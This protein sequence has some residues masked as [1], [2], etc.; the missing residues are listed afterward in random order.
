MIDETEFIDPVDLHNKIFESGKKIFTLSEILELIG[1][2]PVTTAR[3]VFHS[4]W[5]KKYYLFGQYYADCNHCHKSVFYD[6]DNLICPRCG[7]IMDEKALNV[8]W[9]RAQHR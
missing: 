5:G 1:T 7:A 6:R 9:S 4:G 3:R 2:T 8:K